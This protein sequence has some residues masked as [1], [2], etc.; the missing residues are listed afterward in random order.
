MLLSGI[1]R[2]LLAGREA[3]YYIKKPAELP[4]RVISVGNLTMGGTGKT[5]CVIAIAAEAIKRGFK[6]CILTRGYKGIAK[7]TCIVTRGDKPLVGPL[8][9]GDEPFLMAERLKG[10]IIAKDA[11]RYRA[12]LFT[13]TTILDGMNQHVVFILDDG[14]QHRGLRRDTD[15]VLI[16]SN[17]LLSTERLFP[18]GRLR[19]PINALRRAD[20]IVLTKTEQA[21]DSTV[22][23]NRDIIKRLNPSSPLYH[24]RYIADGIVDSSNRVMENYIL[25]GRRVYAF[26]GI[27]DPSHFRSMLLSLGAEIA[28]FRIF[29]DHHIYTAREIEEME[30]EAG[31]LDIITTEKDMVKVKR[32]KQIEN[33]YA[34]RI[35]FS[36]EDGFYNQLFNMNPAKN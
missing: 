7:G 8:E 29:S 36:I 1:Y 4:A 28:G 27:A 21:D 14:F 11:D 2:A 18:E 3:F 35:E 22:S 26:A 13:L 23:K 10:T 33:L 24:S 5:P 9:A 32:I 20:I 34:I 25:K 19:E 31:G 16:D 15:I 6:P 12:G 17:R 30:D